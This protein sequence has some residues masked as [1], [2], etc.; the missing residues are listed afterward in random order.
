VTEGISIFVASGDAGAAACDQNTGSATHGIGV[1]A[2]AST[3]YNVA[4]G[5]T[6][7]ADVLNGTTSQYWNNSNTATYG[8]AIKYIPEIPWNDSCAGGLFASYNGFSTVYGP[9][10][11]CNSQ[12]AIQGGYVFVGGGGGG[13]SNCA[14]GAPAVLGVAGGTCHGYAKPSWQ[15][16]VAGIPADGVRDIPDV[17]MFASDGADWGRYA[18]VCFTDPT[19]GGYP[20]KGA[21]Y[22]WAGFGG[23]SLATPIMAGIQALVNQNQNAKQG[24]PNTVYYHLAVAAPTTFHSI[25]QGDIDQVCNGPYNCYGYIGTVNYG[26][27]GRIF[28][29]T[30]GGAL[31]TSTTSFSSA[32]GT[33]TAWN[34]STGIGSV[35]AFNMVTNWTK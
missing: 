8:S 12:T 33:G 22:N 26:R 34:F 18:V 2:Y 25:T 13:P 4:V 23:T 19:N 17:S 11:F 32:Y 27:G 6:D 28:G 15:T 31:S 5:G 3:P 16:G 30:Y 14:T 24:N 7:F 20:C 29:T 9:N 21:P 10:G 35:D 1:S